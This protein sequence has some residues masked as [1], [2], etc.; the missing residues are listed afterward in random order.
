MGGTVVRAAASAPA[1]AEGGLTRPTFRQVFGAGA[2]G[3]LREGFIPLGAFYAGLRFQGLAAGI[4]A[5]A[6]VSLVIYVYERRRGGDGLLVRIS[7]GFVAVQSAVGLLAHS[8]TVYLAQPVVATAIWGLAFL[9]SAAIGRP[10]AGALA[11]AWYPFPRWFRETPEYK[12]VFGI[13]SIVWGLYFVGRSALR[14]GTLLNGSLE[15]FLLI[16]F[17]TGTPVM[18]LLL[19]WSVHYS[20]RKLS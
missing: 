6:L 4:I 3:F 10:L 11:N 20:L 15:N 1:Q 8:T 12:R 13:E 16:T 19:V 17:L 2:P 18:I 7:L 5:S 14:L 9:V